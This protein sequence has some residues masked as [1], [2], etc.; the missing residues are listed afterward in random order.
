MSKSQFQIALAIDAQ[1]AQTDEH[2]K[3]LKQHG[4]NCSFSQNYDIRDLRHDDRECLALTTPFLK[5]KTAQNNSDLDGDT[6]KSSDIVKD[7]VLHLTVLVACIELTNFL[8]KI[9]RIHCVL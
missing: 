3:S 7:M 4:Y 9:C 8:R 1:R 2:L 6:Q 5:L